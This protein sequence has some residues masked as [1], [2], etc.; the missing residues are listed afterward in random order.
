MIGAIIAG[1]KAVQ[2]FKNEIG[3]GS[4]GA[5]TQNNQASGASLLNSLT[6]KSNSGYGYGVDNNFYGHMTVPSARKDVNVI[7]NAGKAFNKITKEDKAFSR[8]SNLSGKKGDCRK[9]K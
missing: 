5:Q 1:L 8:S 4:G 2:D 9:A 7:G 3:A 6:A